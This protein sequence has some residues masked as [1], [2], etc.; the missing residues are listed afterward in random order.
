MVT[1]TIR[2][3]DLNSIRQGDILALSGGDGHP[4]SPQFG[5]V[6]NADCD[7]AWGRT[8]GVIAVLPIYTFRA[9]LEAFWLPQYLSHEANSNA[10]RVLSVCGLQEKELEDFLQWIREAEHIQVAASLIDRHEVSPKKHKE[11]H[12]LCRRISVILS[13][14]NMSVFQQLCMLERD[15]LNYAKKQIEAAKRSIGD[16][17]FFISDV[18]GQPGIGFVIRMRRI[19][20][21]PEVACFKSHSEMIACTDGKSL[22]GGRVARLSPT[23]QYRV[24]QLFAHQYSRIGL[25]DELTSLSSLAIDE[26]ISILGVK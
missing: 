5:V 15:P 1:E 13:G 8:D 17:H 26:I 25:S 4:K 19:L 2:S 6:I 10:Q 18:A 24:A 3:D 22:S 12:E 20:S 14:Q 11:I 7:L 9:Y 23:Y 21:L 16:G